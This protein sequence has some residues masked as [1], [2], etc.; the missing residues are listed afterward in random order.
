[1]QKKLSQKETQIQ[2][3]S[4]RLQS[5]KEQL[6]NQKNILNQTSEQKEALQTKIDEINSD[7]SGLKQIL[8]QIRQEKEIMK[9]ERAELQTDLLKLREE[10]RLHR[11]KINNL[12]EKKLVLKRR[13]E[14]IKQL[15]ERI[16]KIHK[17]NQKEIDQLKQE[18]GNNGY[19]V[20]NGTSTLTRQNIVKL[21][22]IVVNP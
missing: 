22:E 15:T 8:E 20:K 16:R 17:D 13:H 14:S 10:L 21:K 9:N 5:Y 3:Q 6:L 7:I 11:G 18:F 12:N 19:L 1:M 4:E 2:K